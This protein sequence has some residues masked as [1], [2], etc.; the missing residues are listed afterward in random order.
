[1]NKISVHRRYMLG[2]L[3]KNKDVSLDEFEKFVKNLD[4]DQIKLLSKHLS[5]SRKNRIYEYI[6]KGP[7]HWRLNDIE[8]EKI[9][10]EKVNPTVNMLLE[11]NQWSLLKIAG[12]KEISEHEEFKS[13]G[14]IDNR[15]Q[16]FIAQK[17]KDINGGYVYIVVDGIHRAISLACNGK[18]K[19]RMVYY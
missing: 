12:D 7:D 13:K 15:L 14:D 19:F 3:S 10:V 9:C 2:E 5:T 17:A 18:K 6:S 11:R 1:M 16:T 4:D 8:I